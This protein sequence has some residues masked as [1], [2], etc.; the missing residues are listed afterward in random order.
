MSFVLV[1]LSFVC[2]FVCWFLDAIVS[3]LL[4]HSSKKEET[5]FLITSLSLVFIRR[6]FIGSRDDFLFRTFLSLR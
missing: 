3:F 6:A 4:F 2:L 5:R 1:S